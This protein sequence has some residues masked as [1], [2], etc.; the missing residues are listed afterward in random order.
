MATHSSVFALKIPG[1]GEPGG[2]PS[3]GSHRV[4][5]QLKQ[6]SSRAAAI[7]IHPFV[8]SLNITQGTF[9]EN[10]VVF[11]SIGLSCMVR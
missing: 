1:P 2:L 5:T 7:F 6:L 4:R 11:T 9:L 3:M 10:L 8:L